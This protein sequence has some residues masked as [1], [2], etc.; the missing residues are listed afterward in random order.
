VSVIPPAPAT[1]RELIERHRALP[2][3]G[4][5]ADALVFLL[6]VLAVGVAITGGFTVHPAGVRISVTSVSKVLLW[7]A[8]LVIVRHAFVRRPRVT[9]WLWDARSAAAAVEMGAGVPPPETAGAVRPGAW[10]VMGLFTVLMLAMLHQQVL[11][12]LTVPD[13]GD[14]LFS[15][16]RLAWVAHQLPRDPARL[17][18]GNMFHPE[19]RTLAYSDVMLVPALLVAPLRWLGVHPLLVY[20]LLFLASFALSG[21][22]LFALVWFLTRDR[23]AALLAGLIFA[24]YPYR[25]AHFSHLELQIAWWMP[26]GLLALHRTLLGGRLRDGLA[27]GLAIAGQA[28]SSLYYGLFFV[29]YLVPIA[30]I[31]AL[32]RQ[33]RVV[34]ALKVLAPAAVLTAAIVLP[35]T[36]PYFRNA[37]IVGERDRT[38]IVLG[39][40]RP[41]DY[42][43]APASSA[44]YGPRLRGTADGERQLFPGILPVVLSGVALWPPL[45]PA[46]LA[47]GAGLAVAADVALGV[48][49]ILHPRLYRHARPVRA[50]R[51]PARMGMVVGL[52]LAVLA[53][54][55]AARLRSR[56]SQA[57]VRRLLIVVLAGLALI[58]LRP[59]LSLHPVPADAPAVYR[60]LPRDRT[61]VLLELPF[62]IEDTRYLYY[63]TFHWHTLVNGYSGFFPPSHVA[64]QTA[65]ERFPDDRSIAT[66]RERGVEYVVVHRV[67]Y[68]DHAAFARVYGAMESR[69]EFEFV[70]A[71]EEEGNE[72]RLYRLS[73]RP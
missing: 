26:L 60:E 3:F 25:F 47:Y 57:P 14:P 7:A 44:T 50:L 46:R 58:E 11:R 56:I 16:W 35:V 9:E 51:A 38:D 69:S 13:P 28:L 1:R 27:T 8:L 71:S 45:S 72:T 39:S 21:A 64:M 42:L 67:L 48:N 17:F 29:L 68:P 49:G 53:G 66:M 73:V 30:A 54:Y 41:A 62:G 10:T 20:H 52:T 33:A 34:P 40:A 24:F 31:L 22:A 19:P 6:L 70:A 12:P 36:V 5:V 65:L 63:S 43:A 18:D 4:R 61:A 32:A 59:S 15:V 37:A 55:G 2:C 23:G